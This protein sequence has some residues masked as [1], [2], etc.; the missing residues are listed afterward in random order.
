MSMRNSPI[1]PTISLDAS[2]KR[3]G[4]L[5]LPHSRDDSAW[6]SIMIPI[7]VI[8]N[9][10]GPTALLT[11]ANHGDEYEGPLALVDLAQTLEPDQIRGRVIIVPFM[12]YPAFRAGKR[13]SPIDGGNLNRA[14]PGR[15]DG[16]VTEKIADYFQRYL[17]PSAD[18][19]LDFHSGGKTL[20]FLPYA[21]SHILEDK[22]LET[23]CRAARDA[24]NAPYSLDMLE[25]DALGMYDS[26]AEEMGKI[27]VTTELG[28]A[29]ASDPQTVSVAR[30]G[31]RNL[32]IHANILGGE[33]EIAPSVFL[34]QPGDDCYHFVKT[35]GLI[36]FMVSLGDNVCKGD[37]LARIW[38]TEKTGREPLEIRAKMDGMLITRHH[39]GLVQAGDCLAVLAV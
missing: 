17:L 16:T 10:K 38:N 12:N 34:T 19:V 30:K 26:A 15:P 25:I 23:R 20:N 35:A 7:T 18:I 31:V 33:P 22:E 13:T 21:A 11:G 14:F 28:G 27:F 1:Q 36:D 3:H 4:H 6:G 29:G 8:A 2:G 39:L 24:F 5:V 37:V 32:L 9:G